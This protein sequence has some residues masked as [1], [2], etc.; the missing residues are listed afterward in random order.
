MKVNTGKTPKGEKFDIY[1]VDYPF[2]DNCTD[3]REM[4]LAYECVKEDGGFPDLAE[5]CRKKLKLLDKNFKTEEDFN[6]YDPVAEREANNDVLNWLKEVN[7]TDKK[8][9]ESNGGENGDI[10]S[11]NKE[12]KDKNNAFVSQVEEKRSAENERFKGNEF[13]KSK[14]FE[15]AV[16]CYTKSIEMN[17]NEAASYSN[18]AMAYLKMKK[19]GSCIDDAE[20]AL[21]IDPTYLKAYHRRGKAL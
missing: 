9:R 16:A 10:F 4:R 17:P 13:M 2:V 1:K 19:Y 12:N 5:Y 7:K 18:R 8:L 3:K 21:E 11:T 6:K 14:E 15:F 20:K